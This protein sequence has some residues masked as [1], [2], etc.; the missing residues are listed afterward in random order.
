[1][2]DAMRPLRTFTIEPSL[3]D[4]LRLLMELA[5]NLRWSWQGDAQDLFRRLD[6]GLWEQCYH[7]PVAMLGRMDQVRLNKMASDEG[8]LAHLQ[9]AYDDLQQYIQKPGWWTNTYGQA[10]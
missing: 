10:E 1:M 2:V 8:F 3:P 5:Y 4:D 7:N 9:R 6:P